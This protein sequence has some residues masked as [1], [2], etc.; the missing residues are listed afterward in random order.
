MTTIDATREFIAET[1]EAALEKALTHF[2]VDRDKLE[3]RLVPV[4]LNVAGLAGR[5]LVL[6]SNKDYVPPSGGRSRDRGG[7]RDRGPREARGRDRE[8]GGRDRERGGRDRER[9]AR[10]RGRDRDPGDRDRGDR[11]PGLR[12]REPR[13]TQA[14]APEGPLRVETGD[15]GPIGRFVERICT[16]L[17]RGGSIRIDETSTPSEVQIRVSGD[18][19]ADL[20]G[21]QQ[22][23][24]AAISHLAHRAAQTELGEDASAY[25][26]FERHDPGNGASEDD[27]RLV[28]LARDAAGR[29]RDSGEPELLE[30]MSSRERFVVHNTIRDIDGVA[31]ES[32][33]EGRD[34]RVKV[35][36]D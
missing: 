26:D 28:A 8:R 34:K 23:L 6:V 7:D 36:P 19:A 2:G 11:D 24:A 1:K 16:E 35:L 17:G 18:G 21:R 9:G 30:L 10:D 31:S 29:V 3:V 14:A 13:A 32:V 5:A 25:V 20:V 15:V 22:G 4:E 12:E 33:S 27:E